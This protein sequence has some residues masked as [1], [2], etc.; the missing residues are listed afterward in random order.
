MHTIARLGG[1]VPIGFRNASPYVL[2]E[3]KVLIRAQVNLALR[4]Y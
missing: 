4:V 1:L 2:M 3:F